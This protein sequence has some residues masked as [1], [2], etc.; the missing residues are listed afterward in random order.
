M[1]D[2]L[3]ISRKCENCVQLCAG[4]VVHRYREDITIEANIHL[5]QRIDCQF[6]KSSVLVISLELSKFHI[7][8]R[9][10]AANPEQRS[11]LT[12]DH[13]L[14]LKLRLSLQSIL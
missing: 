8:R 12:R 10:A 2:S 1:S 5:L 13:I 9:M 6:I 14:R 11:L 3:P 4:K 7:V